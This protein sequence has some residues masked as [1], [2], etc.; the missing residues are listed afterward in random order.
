MNKNKNSISKFN[1]IDNTLN[2]LKKE[3]SQKNKNQ[4]RTVLN[5]LIKKS[6]AKTSKE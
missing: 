4:K 2:K 1:N 3:N 6:F 5:K